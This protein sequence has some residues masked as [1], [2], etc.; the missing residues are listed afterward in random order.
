MAR[1]PLAAQ[2]QRLAGEEQGFTRRDLLRTAGAAGAGLALAGALGR[3]ANA[4]HRRRASPSSAP[5]SPASPAPT[6]AAGGLRA[7]R[8]TR[9]SAG[10]AA[11]AGHPRRLRRRPDRRARR[12]ADRPGPH[13][14]P[15]ARP[16]ARAS[17]STT[18]SR[19]RRTAPSRSTTSTA[20]RYTFAEATDDMKQIWQKLHRDLSAASYPTTYNT[21]PQR[22]LELD[23]MSIL[24]W[25][26][27]SR[28]RRARVAARPAARRR[29]QHRVRRRVHRPELAQPALPARLPGQGSC[30]IFG[31][32]NE[33]YHVRGGNDQIPPRLADALARPD[34]TGARAR[35][36]RARTATAR[37]PSRSTGRQHRSVDGRPGGARPAVLDPARRSTTRRPGFEPLKMTA[38]KELAMGTNSK[39][40][41]QFTSRHWRDLGNNGDTYSDT[42]YQNTWEV[43]RA[44]AGT[45]AS[46][47]TTPAARSA[48]ASARHAGRRA[49]S[50]SSTRS[51]RCCP[52]SARS[53]TARRR[54]TTGP[55]TP[56]RKGAYS[57][58]QVGQ[59]TR[60]PA[61][62]EREGNC[63][64]AGEHTSIDFQGYLNGAVETGQ[65]AAAE[66]LADFKKG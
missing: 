31:Q 38:I 61:R 24:D 22:G 19:P 52:G 45:P 11:A 51:S 43:T 17:R 60:S 16:G 55:A 57:Y 59:Y 25:I 23:H 65:R 36:D 6:A 8:S 10:S 14:D 12:R 42:G 39:L 46:S 44:Q 48:R 33:K 15:P 40:H 66:I 34:P 5:A 7:R 62:D 27:A 9:P 18:C 32:S 58:W 53:G 64:F 29:L 49:R 35:R 54:S 26:D 47:S 50:S 20:R 30:G 3:T 2:L 4:R 37:T 13:G 56:G 1:T 63:H 41:V 28:A 21:S